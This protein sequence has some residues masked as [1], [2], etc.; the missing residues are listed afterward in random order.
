VREERSATVV[1]AS[2]SRVCYRF[3]TA[4]QIYRVEGGRQAVP[5]YSPD[6]KPGKTRPALMNNTLSFC[7]S[8]E[9]PHSSG[10][11]YKCPKQA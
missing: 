1:I 4:F 11:M 6:L 3:S 2:P 10:C 5:T 8:E 9:I 7:E